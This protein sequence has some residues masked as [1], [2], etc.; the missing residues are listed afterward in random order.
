MG[1]LQVTSDKCEIPT[2]E[3]HN[4][5]TLIE[6]I[7]GFDRHCKN[8]QNSKY[9]KAVL[10]AKLTNLEIVAARQRKLLKKAEEFQE[11]QRVYEVVEQQEGLLD[12]KMNVLLELQ[13]TP[14]RH[15]QMFNEQDDHSVSW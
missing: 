11:L 6:S 14:S 4:G 1:H 7:K 9:K 10:S 15:G 2:T 5:D 8:T 12:K 3:F 13:N